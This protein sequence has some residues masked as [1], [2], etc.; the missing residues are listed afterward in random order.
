F[1]LDSKPPKMDYKEWALSENRFRMLTKSDPA[2]AEKLLNAANEE[3][4]FR[5]S[6]YEKIASLY[7]PKA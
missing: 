4:K 6:F 1:K 2:A 5:W 7:E 3:N